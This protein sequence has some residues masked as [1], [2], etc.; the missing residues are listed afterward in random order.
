MTANKQKTIAT[1]KIKQIYDEAPKPNK[2]GID[3]V[4]SRDEDEITGR[5]FKQT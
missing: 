4:V 2:K 1:D 5:K 3:A